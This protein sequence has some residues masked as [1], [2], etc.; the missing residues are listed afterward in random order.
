MIIECQTCHARFRLDESRIQGR[1][2]RVKCR[3]CGDSITVLKDGASAPVPPT[4]SDEGFFDLGSAVR[5]SIVDRPPPPAPPDEPAAADFAPA[6]EKDEV[7]L[8]FDRFLSG[9]TKEPLP[10]TGEMGTE[11]PA[12]PEAGAPTLDF[13]PEE[14]LD[15][16]PAEVGEPPVE[17]H[18]PAE[19][20]GYH[21]EGGFLISDSESLAFQKEEPPPSRAEAL[22]RFDDISR[23]ISS[24]PAGEGSSFRRE[25]E[26]SL[27][28]AWNPSSPAA[29]EMALEGNVTPPSTPVMEVLPHPEAKPA[30]AAPS[31]SSERRGSPAPVLP[32]ARSS[33]GPVAAVVLAILLAAGGYF[34]FTASGKKALEGAV[35]GV[36]ALWGGKPAAPTEPKYDLR[37]VI[38]YYESGAAS[39]RILVIKGQVTNLSGVD[40]SGIRVHAALLDNTDAVL[41]QQVVYAGNVLSGDTIRK[42]DR[43]SLSKALGNRFGEGLANM[44]V[45]SGK[46]IPFMVVFFDAPANFESYKLEAKEGE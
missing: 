18:P 7:D 21:G 3:K 2:A 28:P 11:N 25:P 8:A 45:A 13:T 43:E 29:G 42:A 12:P 15:L 4:A 36:A 22:P 37:N 23:A 38:G 35:P 5:D 34:G 16:P 40:K 14:T 9:D 26:P 20:A 19:P 10:S 33:A 32:L 30:P 6:P 41:L 46:S 27:P 31:E 39:P 44:H 1:G 24:A 17:E